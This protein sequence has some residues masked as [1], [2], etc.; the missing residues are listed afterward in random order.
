[1]HGENLLVNDGGNWQA[2]EAIS[3]RLP[4]FNVVSSLAFVVKTVYA[5]DR[6]ALVVAAKNEKVLGVFDFVC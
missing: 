3:K 1:M 6:C 4:Q 2:V 5:V